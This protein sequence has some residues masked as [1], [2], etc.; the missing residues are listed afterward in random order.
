[1]IDEATHAKATASTFGAPKID[2]DKL[3]ECK[4][5]VVGKLTGGLA[6]M[7]KQRKVRVVTGAAQFASPNVLEVDGARAAR[8][9]I[10]FEQCII[11]AGSQPVKLPGFAWDDPR[12]M[13]STDAL[14]L[15]D[16]PKKLLVIGGGIIGL[17]MAMRVSRARQ[18]GHGRRAHD[19]ADA[20]RRS[21]TW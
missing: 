21:R 3:R 1:M 12:V 6:G 15:R 10:R 8:S 2:L 11:A 4:D 20:G 9:C 19:A 17:E 13:D 7:A 18:R 5:K 16:V 14:E